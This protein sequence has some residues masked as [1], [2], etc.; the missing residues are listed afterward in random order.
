MGLPMSF[1]P[2]RW[3]TVKNGA[4]EGGKKD[5]KETLLGNDNTRTGQSHPSIRSTFCG[6]SVSSIE[7]RRKEGMEQGK[8]KTGKAQEWSGISTN[9]RQHGT[10]PAETGDGPGQETSSEPLQTDRR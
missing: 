10:R 2:G 5:E 9:F 4:F 3:T 7:P 1:M 8:K 6:R